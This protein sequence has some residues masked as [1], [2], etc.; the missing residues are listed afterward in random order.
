MSGKVSYL[1]GL[2]AED[3]V[4]RQYEDAGHRIV[5]RRWRGRSG[6]ID[7]VAEKAGE[8]IF[9]EVKASK[10]HA[11]A[12]QSLTGRQQQRIM[13]AAEEFAG[14][15]HGRTNI[16]MRLDVALMDQMG[17]IQILEN[18]LIAA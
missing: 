16:D 9:V 8:L 6:E 2:A 10:T 18:A 4:A 15:H 5:A 11:R 14:K 7:I 1:A 17:A 12:A 3:S 13:R